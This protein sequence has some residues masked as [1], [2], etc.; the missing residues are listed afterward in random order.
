MEQI[1]LSDYWKLLLTNNSLEAFNSSWTP[2]VPKS[3]SIWVVIENFIKEES[4]ARATHS[5]SLRN[6][7]SGHNAMRQR[8]HQVK[9]E[10]LH[11]LCQNY[12]TA[13]SLGYL[14]SIGSVLEN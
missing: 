12:E 7:H 6:V 8:S 4:L 10:Y 2:N 9:M 5:E 1:R 14:E 13:E 3:A 11:M